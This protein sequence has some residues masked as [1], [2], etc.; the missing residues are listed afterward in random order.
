MR[1]PTN[2]ATLPLLTSCSAAVIVDMWASH[3]YVW[4]K[5]LTSMFLILSEE[6]NNQKNFTEIE[7]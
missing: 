4:K 2:D 1:G 7:I 6:S 3:F 5:E